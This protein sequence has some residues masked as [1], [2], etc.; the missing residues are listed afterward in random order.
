[1]NDT[2]KAMSSASARPATMRAVIFK[3]VK[4]VAVEQRPTPTIL[5]PKDVIVKVKATAIC[6]SD[7]H[8][9]RRHM[10]V[11]PGFI[12]GHEFTGIVDEV[13]GEVRGFKV[14]DEVVVG[15]LS[16]VAWP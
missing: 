9:Y 13:G 6:G 15:Y 2:T 4:E 12:V 8:F 14:G 7:L 1:M 3:G 11:P 16:L 5:D 10:K